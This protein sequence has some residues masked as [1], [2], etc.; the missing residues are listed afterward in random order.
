VV[1]GDLGDLLQHP[2]SRLD[3]V[4]LLV[5]EDQ[6][7]QVVLVD[8]R[9]PL[10]S[11]LDQEDLLDPVVLVGLGALGDQLFQDLDNLAAL[12]DLAGRQLLQDSLEDLG[13]LM[14]PVVLVVLE[15]RAET[16][17]ELA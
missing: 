1:Q 13:V 15:V 11:L 10:V 2:E 7:G 8:L 12:V 17:M 6:V 5:Q 14:V 4:D 9:V 3:Q 16:A